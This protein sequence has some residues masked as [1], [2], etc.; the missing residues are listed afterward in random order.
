MIHQFK[1]DDGQPKNTPLPNLLNNF[2]FS[3][4]CLWILFTQINTIQEPIKRELD[5]ILVVLF[6]VSFA[7]V[8]FIV[9]VSFVVVV[10]FVACCCFCC[11][12]WF[13]D[14]YYCRCSYIAWLL[15]TVRIVIFFSVLVTLS[16]AFRRTM[17]T[18]TQTTR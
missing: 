12:C 9:V 4:Q 7:V 18:E 6:G 15:S 5:L 11:C 17:G 8:S 2:L 13:I 3:T 1:L 10:V 14:C 16:C